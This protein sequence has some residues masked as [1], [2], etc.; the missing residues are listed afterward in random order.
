MRHKP[1]AWHAL[2]HRRSAPVHNWTP[3]EVEEV[4]IVWDEGEFAGSIALRYEV[5]ESSI[6]G[7]ARRNGF[8]ARF[9]GRP[10]KVLPP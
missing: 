3:A 4:R 5:S 1:P 9:R 7:L 10:R 8:P 6:L 2:P